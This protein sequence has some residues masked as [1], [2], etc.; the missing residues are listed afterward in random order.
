MK[1]IPMPE[2]GG[3]RNSNP[4]YALANM[5]VLHHFVPD[6]PLRVSALRSLGAYH[7]VFAVESMMD[8]LAHAAALDPLAFRLAHMTDER[9][10]AAMTAATDAI[11]WHQRPKGDGRRGYGMAF[12][13]YKNLG[14]YCAIAMEVSVDRETGAITVARVH[15][16]VDSGQA[17]SPDGIRNQVEGGIVQSLSWTRHESV[18]FDETRQ[19][20]Y[21]WSGYP[22]ARFSD[23]PG[24][25]QVEV[26]DRP[27]LPFLGTGEA[28]QGPTAAALANAL[29]DATGLRFRDLPLTADKVKAAIGAI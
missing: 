8:E 16:A 2:G 21:D 27:G 23:V 15:A 7:N 5:R 10:R 25:V 29:A 1:P 24:A 22:I 13:R 11:G 6:M 4:L 28:A 18:R 17:A 12:A 3:D 14:A 26:L 19:L 20:S 9:A